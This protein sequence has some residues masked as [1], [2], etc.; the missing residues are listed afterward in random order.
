MAPCGQ[1]C[2]I[3]LQTA[4]IRPTPIPR[5]TRNGVLT[6]NHKPGKRTTEDIHNFARQKYASYRFMGNIMTTRQTRIVWV[7]LFWVAVSQIHACERP[8]RQA[9]RDADKGDG[10]RPDVGAE[11]GGFRLVARTAKNAYVIGEPIVV[12]VD[13]ENLTAADIKITDSLAGVDH[14]FIVRTITGDDVGLTET[15]RRRINGPLSHVPQIVR[16]G[17]KDSEQWPINR[18]HRMDEEGTYIII[19]VRY[20]RFKD[21]PES[22]GYILSNALTVRILKEQDP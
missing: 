1:L 7:F 15:G 14:R 3:V 12:N 4:T 19:A 22:N 5:I 8:A 13:L 9:A 17:G 2:R 10:I 20:L 11:R 16:A 21:N 6:F 18:L